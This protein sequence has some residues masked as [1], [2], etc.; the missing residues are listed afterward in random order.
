MYIMAYFKVYLLFEIG[1]ICQKFWQELGSLFHKCWGM[2]ANKHTNTWF[3]LN[4]V[5]FSGRISVHKY[6]QAIDNIFWILFNWNYRGFFVFFFN[7][8]TFLIFFN[9]FVLMA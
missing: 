7:I 4:P 8:H 1:C 9:I 5:L 3:L 6:M 2:Q